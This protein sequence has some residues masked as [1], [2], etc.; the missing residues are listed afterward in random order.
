MEPLMITDTREPRT[1]GT[2]RAPARATRTATA[3][4][5]ADRPYESPR[6]IPRVASAFRGMDGKL[7]HSRCGRPIEFVGVRGGIELDFHCIGCW[8]H[9]TLTENALTRV[10]VGQD[11]SS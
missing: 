2:R 6:T 10:P 3:T 1:T 8:E 5:S 7:R 11:S 9:V 4:P